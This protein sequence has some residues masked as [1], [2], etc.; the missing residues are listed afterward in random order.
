VLDVRRLRVLREVARRGSLA[1]AADALSYTPSAVSQ[2]VAALEREAGAA[3]LERRSRGVVLTEAGHALVRHAEVILGQLDAAEAELSALEN[4]RT[5][6]LRM[7][8]FATAGASLL[9][10]AVDAFRAR[11]P[12]VRLSVHQASPQESVAGLREG[13][14]DVALTVD[15]E[16]APAEGVEVVHLFDDPVQLALHVDHPLAA[17]PEIRLADLREE[18]WIDVPRRTSGGRVLTRAC[19]RAGFAPRVAYE[20]DDYTAIQELVGAG[21]GLALLPDL[22]LCPPHELVVLRTLAADRPSRQIQAALRPAPFRS[23]A[24]AAMLEILRVQRPLGR[25]ARGQPASAVPP[26]L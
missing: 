14:L 23:P 21:V 25:A 24:A 16:P 10:L 9:P 13:A 20:S 12:D 8:S 7:A 5:G 18:T 26:S 3:L 6:R 22:A 19:E 2:Q 15:L 17:R 11:H 1:A 4:L